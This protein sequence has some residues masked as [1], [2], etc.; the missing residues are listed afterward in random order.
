M[1][2]LLSW[3]VLAGLGLG[4]GLW[5][6][7]S[8][9]PRLRGP[10]LADRVAPFIVDVSASARELAGRTT[11]DPLPL[12]GFTLAPVAAALRATAIAVFGIGDDLARRL[13]QAGEALE[14]ERF[15]MGQLA[16]SLAGL[17]LG[18]AVVVAAPA[19]RSAPLTVQF[20]V[21]LVSAAVGF[22]VKGQLLQRRA[23]KRLRRIEQELP[24]VLE[25]LALSLAAGEGLGD[26]L[27]RITRAGR[28][29]LSRELDIALAE[30]ATGVPLA[31]SL[32]VLAGELRLPGLSRAVEALVAAMDQGTPLAEVLLAQAHD[33]RDAAKRELI[34]LAGK[35]ELA[36]LVPLV[37]LILPVT[38]LFAIYPGVFVLNAGFGE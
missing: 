21:P 1:N 24:T 22:L 34:E 6:V 29:E 37:F 9:L 18:A 4:V 36:M 33:A 16:S 20:S 32:R 26:G 5:L 3:A 35:K 31:V 13:R 17:A 8:R 10:R 30:T 25:F 23:R 11:V 2:P 14:V 28:G 27:R 7:V 12:F 19:V 38:V 15:R